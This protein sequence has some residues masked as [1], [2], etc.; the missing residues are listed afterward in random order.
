MTKQIL[1]GALLAGICS[2]ANAADK[3][4]EGVYL[5]SEEFCAQAKADHLQTVIEAGNVILTADGIQS[6]EYDCEFVRI[7]KG[8]RSPA[9]VVTALC[10][11]PGYLFPD[12]F[13]IIQLSPTQ[14][15]LVS[16]RPVDPEG[17]GSDNGGSYYLCDGVEAP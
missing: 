7:D 5:Q 4:I 15:D 16:V 8:T 13:S 1:L 2:T 6:I 10:Q 11:E 17:G 12:V 14:L 3:F 9:W